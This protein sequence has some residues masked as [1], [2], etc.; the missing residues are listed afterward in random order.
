MKKANTY[1]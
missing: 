1:L